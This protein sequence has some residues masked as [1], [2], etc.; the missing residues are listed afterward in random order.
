MGIN[1]RPAASMKSETWNGDE[2]KDIDDECDALDNETKDGVDSSA[3]SRAQK[4]VWDKYFDQM[5]QSVQD[6]YNNMKSSKEPGKRLKMNALVNAA[7][8]KSA[9]YKSSANLKEQ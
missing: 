6:S 5:P 8:D 2:A 9:T 1:K 7:V 3:P 4:Y